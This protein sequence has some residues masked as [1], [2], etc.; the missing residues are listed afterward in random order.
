MSDDST[1][2]ICAHPTETHIVQLVTGDPTSEYLRSSNKGRNNLAHE[3]VGTVNAQIK[4]G[5]YWTE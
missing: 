2:W 3:T 4:G 5:T 1:Y